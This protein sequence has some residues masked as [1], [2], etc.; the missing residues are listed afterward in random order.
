MGLTL[1]A[2][3]PRTAVSTVS[4][5]RKNPSFGENVLRELMRKI[6]FI[7]FFRVF[8]STPEQPT[9]NQPDTQGNADRFVRMHADGVV[10]RSGAFG[11]LFSDAAPKLFPHVQRGRKAL[12]G[13]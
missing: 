7:S 6:F 5:P 1:P 8:V 11:G 2:S 13:L 3:W 4:T 12:P 10:G 9:R